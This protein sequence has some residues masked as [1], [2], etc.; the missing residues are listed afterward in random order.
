MLFFLLSD[1][2]RI[3]MIY[4]DKIIIFSDYK[5]NKSR[6]DVGVN[7]VLVQFAKINVCINYIRIK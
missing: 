1:K 2:I 7:T 6:T 4:Y 5:N 3:F